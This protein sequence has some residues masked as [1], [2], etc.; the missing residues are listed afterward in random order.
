M[1][2]NIMFSATVVEIQYKTKYLSN[3][4][5]PIN[6]YFQKGI[7]L[8]NVICYNEWALKNAI[9]ERCSSWFKEHAWKACVGATLPGV[10]IPFSP[11]VKLC[12]AR[13]GDSGAL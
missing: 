8:V 3:Y 1:L 6:N 12:R 4:K 7:E 13:W 9:M 10:R 11:P 5:A 2:N